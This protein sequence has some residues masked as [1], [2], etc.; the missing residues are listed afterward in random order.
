MDH[1]NL[2]YYQ[3]PRKI[4]PRVTRYLLE[5]EQYNI[6]LEYKLGAT[7]RADEL[8]H[9]EDH[10][11]GSNLINKDITVWP[12][13]YFCEQHKK[14]R[15]F[16]MDSIY[17]SLE[18]QCKQVQYKEQDTLKHWA[19]AHNLS[20]LDGTHWYK[21]TALVVMEDNTLRRGVT[22]LFHNSTTSSH[23]RISKTLQL[24]QPYYW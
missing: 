17:D 8:S 20:I 12:D 4:G 11:T 24:L 5:W 6:L 21:G 23:P 19:A 22:S 2:H 9:C 7:N 15:V 16:D 10:D 1:A 13:H 18:N 14:I 3:E